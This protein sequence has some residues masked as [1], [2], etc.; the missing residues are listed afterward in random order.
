MVVSS[1]ESCCRGVL[2]VSRLKWGSEL[3]ACQRMW[4]CQRIFQGDDRKLA[5]R[6]IEEQWGRQSA[7]TYVA[8]LWQ[9]VSLDLCGLS[10]G[11]PC[12]P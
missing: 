6:V 7:W 1:S 2:S 8:C 3:W 5:I 9:T 10:A 4:A 12:I 11:H